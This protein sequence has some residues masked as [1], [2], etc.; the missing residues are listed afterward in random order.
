LWRWDIDIGSDH[1]LAAKKNFGRVSGGYMWDANRRADVVILT[2]I[3]LEYDAAREVNAGAVADSQWEEIDGPNGLP[4]AFREFT[5]ATGRPL[6]I[7]LAVSP[8]MGTTAATNTLLPLVERLQPRC[9]AMCGVCA[10]RRGKTN[11]GDVVA[12]ERLYYH[13]AGKRLP[14]EIQQDL[15]TYKLRDDWKVSLEGLAVH[16]HFGNETWLQARPLPAEWRA[17]RALHAIVA[18]ATEPWQHIDPTMDEREWET[19][20]KMLRE[21]KLVFKKNLSPTAQ[22]RQHIRP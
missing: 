2:A 5:V 14:D 12:A 10:G 13:D 8:D 18:G 3:R 15:T 4:V 20:L 17:N 19:V 6:R 21:A 1:F 11:L 7:A 16:E 22:G 9:I